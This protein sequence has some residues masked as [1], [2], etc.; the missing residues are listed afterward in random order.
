MEDLPMF[1]EIKEVG[2]SEYVDAIDREDSRVIVLVHIYEDQVQVCRRINNQLERLARKY[3]RTKFVRMKWTEAASK[4]DPKALPCIVGYRGGDVIE[5]FV[6]I[7]ELLP[8]DFEFEDIEWLLE[9]K[10]LLITPTYDN[11]LKYKQEQDARKGEMGEEE[12]YICTN[13]T[14]S[15]TISSRVASMKGSSYNYADLE[16]DDLEDI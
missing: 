11:C 1:G 7:H 4:L 15:K 9:E 6:R 8:A 3:P 10:D 13:S 14:A 2:Q 5:S 16:D 12:N